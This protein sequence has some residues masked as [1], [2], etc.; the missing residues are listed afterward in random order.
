MKFFITSGFSGFRF[1]RA[2]R[3]DQA[4]YTTNY[5]FIQR[6]R[7]PNR[8]SHSSSKGE[9]RLPLLQR[10]LISEESAS[11]LVPR[12]GL[13]AVSSRSSEPVHQGVLKHAN[14]ARACSRKSVVRRGFSCAL[15]WFALR[16]WDSW[17]ALGI[18][19][20][21]RTRKRSSTLR[22]TVPCASRNHSSIQLGRPICHTTSPIR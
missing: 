15:H 16:S 9:M 8:T 2:M 5:I 3:S 10:E 17:S 4:K 1:L 22:F 19:G 18:P 12:G 13:E 7:P 6:P 20:W 11:Q 21:M 14:A